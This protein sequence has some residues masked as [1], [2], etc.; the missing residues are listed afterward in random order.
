MVILSTKLLRPLTQKIVEGLPHAPTCAQ[1]GE[2]AAPAA[3]RSAGWYYD[4]ADAQR[5]LGTFYCPKHARLEDLD[6]D[7]PANQEVLFR[8]PVSRKMPLQVET[9]DE[10]FLD[11]EWHMTMRAAQQ[12]ENKKWWVSLP[13]GFGFV[14]Y[15]Y[16]TPSI[17]LRPVI[18]Q[19][20]YGDTGHYYVDITFRNDALALVSLKYEQILGQRYVCLVRA[21]EVLD[22]FARRITNC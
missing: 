14:P 8:V 6:P 5:G 22:F 18:D 7:W 4:A 20:V 2:R 15:Q 11:L 9:L 10:L 21:A 17:K 16:V 1:C 19:M 12:R 13:V 3:E